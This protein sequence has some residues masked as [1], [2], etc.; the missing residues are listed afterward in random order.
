MFQTLITLIVGFL[1]CYI[2]LPPLIVKLRKSKIV[3]VDVHKKYRPI[4]PEMG[5]I[6]IIIGLTAS[7]LSCIVIFPDKTPMLLVFLTTVLM[8]GAVGALDDFKTL[9]A[10][11][12]PLLTALASIPILL[13]R[14]YNPFPILPFVGPTRLTYVYPLLMPFAISIPSNAVNMMD[15]FNGT[16]AGT[17]IVVDLV[18]IA[19][20]LLLGRTDAV[21]LAMCLLGPLL[22]FYMFNRYPSKIFSG[23]VGS[24]SVGAAL[25]AIAVLGQLE[26]VAI[27]AFLP[28]VMN[29]FFG[30]ATIGRLFE[31]REVSRP[32][33]VM[34]D[35]KL[36][37]SPDA[38]APITLARFAL[39]RGPLYEYEAIRLFM[40]FSVLSGILAVFTA[41][42]SL[43]TI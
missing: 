28:Q 26:V 11:V 15:P 24:L 3:G 25:G 10:K 21:I 6:A 19:S 43:V 42:L 1:V 29:A 41:Y 17:C 16:M 8:A 4:V 20:G 38:K 13:T 22:A 7:I 27:V 36:M 32:I 34:D 12:K 23:D 18:L 2:A 9:R 37:V 40:I 39:A 33:K 31:R 14:T 30:L 5:G 35:G